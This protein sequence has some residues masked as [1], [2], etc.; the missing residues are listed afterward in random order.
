MRRGRRAPRT[1]LLAPRRIEPTEAPPEGTVSEVL[2]WV[3]DDPGRA[4]QALDAERAGRR[5]SSLIAELERLGA[6]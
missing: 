6:A 1:R 4:G 2:R 3:G 5:R